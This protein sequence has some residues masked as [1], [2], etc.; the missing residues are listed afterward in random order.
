MKSFHVTVF[1]GAQPKPGDQLYT[2]GLLLGRLL[3][4]QGWTVLTGGYI[5]TME[6]VSRG[7][8]ESGSHVIGITC[9][10]IE[11]WR[12]SKVNAWVT[13]EIKYPNLRERLLALI[14]RCDAALALPGGIGTLTE[15]MM[16]WNQLV[17]HTIAPRPLI[18]IGAGWLNVMKSLYTELG[19][20]IPE[21]QREWI[22][23]ADDPSQAVSMLQ[24][25]TLSGKV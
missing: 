17:V 10:D 18:L 11:D 1:G 7:A 4:E 9:S 24:E 8:A 23:F 22:R 15:I 25:F 2:D 14:D 19:T 6:A 21:K 13:E 5:G 16:T 3:G 20:Y 12:G